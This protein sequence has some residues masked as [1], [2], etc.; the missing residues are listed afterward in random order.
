MCGGPCGLWAK[1]P[2]DILPLGRRAWGAEEV[3]P[4]GA[5][6]FAFSSPLQTI[7]CASPSASAP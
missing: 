5:E 1:L 3:R 2:G 7:S 4:E 6:T